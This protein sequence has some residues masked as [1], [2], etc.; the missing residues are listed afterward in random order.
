M[1]GTWLAFFEQLK[2]KL[3]NKNISP[4][5]WN[6][7]AKPGSRKI[8]E[9]IK[10]SVEGRIMQYHVTKKVFRQMATAHSHEGK[11]K[12]T[13]CHRI[14]RISNVSWGERKV[15]AKLNYHLGKRGSGFPQGL[16]N[17]QY[18]PT[19]DIGGISSQDKFNE[20]KPMNTVEWY[21]C[22]PSQTQKHEQ[23]TLGITSRSNVLRKTSL[24][25]FPSWVN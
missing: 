12:A 4:T 21:Q 14:S 7:K 3:K 8:S 18:S 9:A 25:D 15:V 22:N 1:L 19:K 24:I 6:L 10:H 20:Q 2:S 16:L 17:M 5:F 13:L 23:V 11:Q